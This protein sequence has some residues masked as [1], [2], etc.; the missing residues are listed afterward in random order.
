MYCTRI[1]HRLPAYNCFFIYSTD[2]GFTICGSTQTCL[3][4]KEINEYYNIYMSSEICSTRSGVRKC[5][6]DYVWVWSFIFTQWLPVSTTSYRQLS[7]R[8][9]A[10][11]VGVSDRSMKVYTQTDSSRRFKPARDVAVPVNN[12][13]Q[14]GTVIALQIITPRV[15]AL[16]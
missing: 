14:D 11:A 1:A 16:E 12:C 9:V 10:I 13:R 2:I 8:T 3:A 6:P 5:L 15:T 4:D 7:L